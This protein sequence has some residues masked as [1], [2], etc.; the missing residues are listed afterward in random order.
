MNV[1]SAPRPAFGRYDML[2]IFFDE[3][4]SG[5]P[6]RAAPHLG[7]TV[8]APG[9]LPVVETSPTLFNDLIFD[10]SSS[11]EFGSAHLECGYNHHNSNPNGT[12]GPFW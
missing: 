3:R 11:F 5:P 2:I 7:P 9:P 8:L 1:T 12:I 10:K 6:L 4:S